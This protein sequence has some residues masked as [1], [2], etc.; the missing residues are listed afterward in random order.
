MFNG[1]NKTICIPNESAS[2][3]FYRLKPWQQRLVDNLITE[4]QP[5]SLHLRLG[6]SWLA[7]PVL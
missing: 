2:L 6:D 3:L 4:Y 7:H 1:S 5:T